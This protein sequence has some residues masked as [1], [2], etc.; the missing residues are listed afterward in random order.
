MSHTTEL[1]NQL[2][3]LR[4]GSK[5][6][7]EQLI[8]HA[9]ER[10]RVLTRKMLK[11]FPGVQ[12]WSQ[13]DDVLQAA[14]LK[15]HRALASIQPNSP[16]EFYGLA[17]TQIR[18]VLLDLARHFSGPEGIGANHKTDT[19]S[20]VGGREFRDAE[21]SN[22]EEWSRFHNAVETL[23]DEQRQAVDLVWYEGMS[24]SEAADVLNVSL[25][26]LKRRWAAAKM[27]LCE[28]IEDWT[29]E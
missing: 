12:R 23:P 17:A 13:T 7:R 25:A 11:R 28:V 22:I 10:L 20:I 15:L 9:C 4:N 21:P 14:L 1:K 3:Q 6:A 8:E 19:G 18:R 27:T 16:A 5:E 24:Q 2:E 29:V 26:T